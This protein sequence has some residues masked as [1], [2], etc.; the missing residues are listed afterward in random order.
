MNA[1]AQMAK[2]LLTLRIDMNR[3]CKAPRKNS[4]SEMPASTP[5]ISMPIM[6]SPADVP[7][8]MLLTVSEAF[9]SMLRN[10]CSRQLID[11]GRWR[12]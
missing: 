12:L 6:R 8:I 2:C 1:A 5:T 10:V 3:F 7:P 9:S 11:S 4:S